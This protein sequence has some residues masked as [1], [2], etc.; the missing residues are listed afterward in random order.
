ML[1]WEDL[2]LFIEVFISNYILTP[3]TQ[4]N[5]HSIA[6]D[7]FQSFW[8]TLTCMTCCMIW[9]L[10]HYMNKQASEC[11]HTHWLHTTLLGRVR[12]V[13][14]ES[15][16]LITSPCYLVIQETQLKFQYK[17]LITGLEIQVELSFWIWESWL[18]PFATLLW[19]Q[20]LYDGNMLPLASREHAGNLLCHKN[21][22]NS[23]AFNKVSVCIIGSVVSVQLTGSYLPDYLE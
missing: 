19:N 22:L 10:D 17:S 9:G 14:L 20:L 3:S 21:T 2:F 7:L 13:G 4:T 15:K 5:H 8:L 11:T 16:W 6:T 12:N 23:S 1:Q 18:T